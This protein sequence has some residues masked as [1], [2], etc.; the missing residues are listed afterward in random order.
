MSTIFVSAKKWGFF[1]GDN[2]ATGIE[3]PE[4]KAVRQKH[5]LLPEQIPPLFGCARIAR[6]HNGFSHDYAL[7]TSLLFCHYGLS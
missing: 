6:Q 3:L 5:V 4:K 7:D 2:P 1:A